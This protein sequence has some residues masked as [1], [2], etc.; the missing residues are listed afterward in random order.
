MSLHSPPSGYQS[1]PK[2]PSDGFRSLSLSIRYLFFFS[3]YSFPIFPASPAVCIR[4]LPTLYH[5]LAHLS[6]RTLIARHSAQILGTRIFYCWA[7]F[8]LVMTATRPT[9]TSSDGNDLLPPSITI[10][11]FN[12]R[13]CRTHR[14]HDYRAHGTHHV[15]S[16]LRHAMTRKF[17]P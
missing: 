10:P 15:S 16:S 1:T 9:P 6:R 8:A 3:F 12:K 4:R 14:Q 7:A 13:V 11:H 5:S 2:M 17:G